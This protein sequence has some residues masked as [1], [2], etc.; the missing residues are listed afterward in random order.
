MK[1]ARKGSNSVLGIGK[2]KKKNRFS[3]TGYHNSD[4]TLYKV[5]K[6]EDRELR[7][8][9]FG[10]EDYDLPEDSVTEETGN[11]VTEEHK[12]E[13]IPA[14]DIDVPGKETAEEVPQ[15][16]NAPE[17]EPEDDVKIYK[18]KNSGG[19]S[20]G[21]TGGS[22]AENV[23][24]AEETDAVTDTAAEKPKKKKKIFSK[25]YAII[26]A[27]SLA[28]I[29]IGSVIAFSIGG[30]FNS[31]NSDIT[32]EYIEPVDEVTGKVNVLVLGV[33]NEGLRTDTMIVASFDTDDGKV[34]M[35]S[36]PRDT[37]MYIGSRYQKINA[38]HAISKKGGKIAGPEGS[39]EAVTRLTGIP[40]NY[41]VE[42]S[43]KAFR[44]TID[45]LGGVY[46]NVPQNMNY[47]D[48][49]QKLYIHLKQGYQLLDGDKAEQLVRFRSYPEGDIKRVK[50]QQDFIK[51]LAGQKLNAGIIGKLPDL[52]K[53]LSKNIKSNFTA[54]DVAKYG[55]S[56]MNLK[57]E[58]L[59]A[60]SLPGDYSG[61]E[62]DASYWLADMKATKELVETVFGYDTTYTTIDKPV[63]GA[64]Y[65][66]TADPSK[67]A[68]IQSS[69]EPSASP[70]ASA[71]EKPKSTQSATPKATGKASEKPKK[72]ASPT[73]KADSKASKK[74]AESK[75]P[76]ESK[77]P[78]K[79]AT[80]APTEK[81]KSSFG[82]SSRDGFV[83]GGENFDVSDVH[84]PPAKTQ[85]PTKAPGTPKP[86]EPAVSIPSTQKP[87]SNGGEFQRPSP[88]KK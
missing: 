68:Q 19:D 13:D 43:F 79:T 81:P 88:N 9:Y 36:I 66:K 21:D 4:D 59:T 70:T 26:F 12:P 35:L 11:A 76:E 25:K 18:P 48:P 82:S 83:N 47:E 67:A 24:A 58:N 45:A 41:Y 40:I 86:T 62:Y 69:E 61:S 31:I 87:S 14:N 74:P 85:T 42:F 65:G 29:L 57:L 56:L 37:R 52:Y 55:G 32:D 73:A 22:N 7:K 8:K 64:V 60:Y 30:F 16:E 72:S 50:V 39:I 63:E 2:S 10:D 75:K 84:T 23:T 49:T 20:D 17:P 28:V 78:E 44:E 5:N 46:Y 3:E 53:T 6:E 38:A 27:V 77:E 80:P 54:S 71:S 34:D 1:R 51:E 15:E 33:D